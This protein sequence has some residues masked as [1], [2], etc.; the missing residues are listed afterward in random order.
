[1]KSLIS[2]GPDVRDGSVLTLSDGIHEAI[3]TASGGDTT[4]YVTVKSGCLAPWRDVSSDRPAPCSCCLHFG[5]GVVYWE[6][7]PAVLCD[8]AMRCLAQQEG[9]S[10]Y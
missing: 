4:V 9:V 3:G 10:R 8:A 5:A 2:D 6:R 7:R 1:M